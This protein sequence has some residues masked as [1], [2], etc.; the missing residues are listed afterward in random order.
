M[1]LHTL[2]LAV[3]SNGSPEPWQTSRLFSPTSLLVW[4]LKENKKAREEIKYEKGSVKRSRLNLNKSKEV[5]I[6]DPHTQV[7]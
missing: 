6:P 4:H 1:F 2:A 5:Q 3:F 7:L